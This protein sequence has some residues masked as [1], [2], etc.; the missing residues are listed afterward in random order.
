MAVSLEAR[1]PL[2]DH[3][4]AEY[5]NGLP[6]SYKLSL[7]TSKRVFRHALRDALPEPVLRRSKAGFAVTLRPW[8]RGP[9]REWS[10]QVLLESC[11]AIFDEKGVSRALA[12]LDGSQRDFSSYVWKLI[13]LGVWA[14]NQRL[15]WK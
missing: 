10:R 7:R 9:L 12:G 11:P 13:A 14:R 3:T 5:V 8:L 2:L 6:I 4:L 15:S 1:V